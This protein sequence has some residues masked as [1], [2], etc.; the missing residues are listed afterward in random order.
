MKRSLIAIAAVALSGCSTLDGKMDNRLACTVAGDM[1]YAISEYGPVGISAKISDKD[2][3]VVCRA[4]EKA[5]P[6]AAAPVGAASGVK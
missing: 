1:L 3:A 2:R 6:A 4:P 5:A